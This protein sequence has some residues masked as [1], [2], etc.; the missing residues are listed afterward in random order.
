MDYIYNL[1]DEWIQDFGQFRAGFISA[2]CCFLVIVVIFYIFQLMTRKRVREIIIPGDRGALVVSAG[3]VANMVHTIIADQFR[4]ITIKKIILWRGNR[5]IVME[6]QGSYDIDG[7]RLPEVAN[8]MR[9]AILNNLDGQLG[10][11]TI[12]EVV[13]NIKKITANNLNTGKFKR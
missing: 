12:R 8:E 5:G 2:V 7:G 13:P 9:E 3:A 6:V 4:S 10:I 11:T 1:R